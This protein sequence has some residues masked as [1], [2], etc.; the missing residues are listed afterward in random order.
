MQ[1]LVFLILLSNDVPILLN[2]VYS[3]SWIIVVVR[4]Q[5]KPYSSESVNKIHVPWL[6]SIYMYYSIVILF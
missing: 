3:E 5:S 1:K 4:I 6:I 2:F